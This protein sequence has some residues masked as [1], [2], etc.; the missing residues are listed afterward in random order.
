[1]NIK[2]KRGRPKKEMIKSDYL[3]VSEVASMLKLST[4]HIYT[5]TSTKK[6]PYIKLCGRKLLFDKSEINN[7]LKSKKVGVK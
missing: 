5:L 4:S 6:I 2:V 1:M 7:W 3:S